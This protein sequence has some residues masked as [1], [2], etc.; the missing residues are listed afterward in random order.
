M[1]A[2]FQPNAFQNDAYQIQPGVM[3]LIP[4]FVNMVLAPG[5]IEDLNWVLADDQ[6]KQR[7]GTGCKNSINEKQDNPVCS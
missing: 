5:T 1:T 2:A 7:P 4:D 3:Y 6:G